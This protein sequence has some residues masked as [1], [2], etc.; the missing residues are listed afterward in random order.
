MSAKHLQRYVNECCG[1]LNLRG[2]GTMEQIIRVALGSC[3]KRLTFRDLVW[4]Q[5]RSEMK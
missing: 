4:E 2:F 3:G 5:T 1:R